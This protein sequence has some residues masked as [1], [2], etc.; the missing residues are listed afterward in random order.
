MK[1]AVSMYS[2]SKWRYSQNKTLEQCLDWVAGTNVKAVE[3]G[4]LGDKAEKIGRVRYAAQLRRRCKR[5]GL[6]VAGY[7]RP[8]NLLV[9]PKAQRAMVEQLKIEVDTAAAFGCKTMRH[10]VAW[11]WH[12]AK[13]V[14]G[15]RTFAHAVKIVAP[16]IRE[17]ADYA[18]QRG[19]VTSLENHGF[20]VQASK[21]VEYLLKQVAHPNFALTIDMGNFLCVREDPVAAVRRLAKYAVMAHVK[22][23]HVKAKRLAPPSGWIE[24][25]TPIAIRGAIVGHGE[26]DVPA[27]LRTLKSAGYK[28]YLSL[29]FEGL[30]EPRQA[31][32]LGLEYVR[33]KL[34]EIG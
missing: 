21:R 16:A 6:A 28:G 32:E 15:P 12:T 10:D 24:T 33:K 29:E 7:C 20:F 9:G 22:D 30:E 5:L 34:R 19:V 3:F 2:L 27:Q 23:F 1:L 11:G 13:R 17:I 8:A 4:D 26:I 31:I 18:Q 14:A 25:P